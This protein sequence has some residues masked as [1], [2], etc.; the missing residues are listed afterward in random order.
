MQNVTV[1]SSSNPLES[2]LLPATICEEGF[3]DWVC[4]AFMN[5]NQPRPSLSECIQIVTDLG[6]GVKVS[7]KE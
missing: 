7:E 6:Y 4:E 1:V 2:F 3:C 5:A